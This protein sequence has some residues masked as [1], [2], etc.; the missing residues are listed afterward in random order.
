MT[1]QEIIAAAKTNWLAWQ[2]LKELQPEV[3]AWMDGHKSDCGYYDAEFNKVLDVGGLNLDCRCEI[4]RLRPDY[5]PVKWWFLPPDKTLAQYGI[6]ECHPERPNASWLEVTPEYADYLRNKPDG[7]WELRMAKKGDICW[8]WKV[9]MVL[10]GDYGDIDATDRG[11]RW[12]KVAKP[13]P[14]YGWREYAVT[15]RNGVY[16]V[17]GYRGGDMALHKALCRVGFG[18]VQFEGLNDWSM[19]VPAF[20]GS[21]GMLMYSSIKGATLATPIKTRFWEAQ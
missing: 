20:I 1:E 8:D 18:G 5:E 17:K 3:A 16:Y 2:G 15:E 19:V 21:H 10:N 7:E 4:Y 6:V 13:G 9:L 14:A 11:Y 12:C